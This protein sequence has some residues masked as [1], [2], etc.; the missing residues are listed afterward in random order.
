MPKGRFCIHNADPLVGV[1]A[2][3]IAVLYDRTVFQKI[4]GETLKT[5]TQLAG[6]FRRV[7]CLQLHVPQSDHAGSKPGAGVVTVSAD[8][9]IDPDVQRRTVRQ[10]LLGKLDEDVLRNDQRSVAPVDAEGGPAS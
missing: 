10:D 2:Y 1:L 9:E 3:R 4:T 5:L 6:R 8:P 7:L